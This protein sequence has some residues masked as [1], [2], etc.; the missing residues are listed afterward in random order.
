M[1]CRY[2]I[3]IG[4]SWLDE[5]VVVELALFRV[6]RQTCARRK[7]VLH[8]EKVAGVVLLQ[9]IRRDRFP[10]RPARVLLQPRVP[11]RGVGYE[12]MIADVQFWKIL[13]QA[14][15]RN[16]FSGLTCIRLLWMEPFGRVPTILI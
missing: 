2:L 11:L 10:E 14:G 16:G 1:Y 15:H 6:G 7:L 9:T 12:K 4:Y 3:L 5:V 13:L 8:D